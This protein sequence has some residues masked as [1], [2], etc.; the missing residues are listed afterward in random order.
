MI[1][2]WPFGAQVSE[3]EVGFTDPSPPT[4]RIP[5]LA[6][7]PIFTPPQDG[8]ESLLSFA[9]KSHKLKWLIRGAHQRANRTPKD[10]NSSHSCK[11]YS[12]GA[13]AILK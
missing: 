2:I 7:S 1:K 8:N 6:I 11:D 12:V 9:K 5:W 3:I 4:S 13:C 10:T